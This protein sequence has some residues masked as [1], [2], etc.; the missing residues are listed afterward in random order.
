MAAKD[1]DQEL[2]GQSLVTLANGDIPE[3][4]ILSEQHSAGAKSAVYMI[5][6]GKWKY[7]HY[8]E[9]YPAQ[10]F[11]LEADPD[12]LQDLG[13]N[14]NFSNDLIELGKELRTHMDPD[15]VDQKAKDRQAQRLELAGGMEAVLAKGSPGYT[16]APGEEPEYM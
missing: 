15:K 12:E 9:G 6:K 10:L 3:R 13:T 7:V 14:P 4:S 1:E 8:V 5:R 11:D 2:P 16:P